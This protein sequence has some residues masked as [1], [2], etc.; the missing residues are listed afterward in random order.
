MNIAWLPL[1]VWL[2]IWSMHISWW[3]TGFWVFAI[4]FDLIEYHRALLK[5]DRFASDQEINP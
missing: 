2:A 1:H 3:L 4:A 5:S